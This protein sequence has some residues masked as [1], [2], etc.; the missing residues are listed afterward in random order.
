[1]AKVRSLLEL[2]GYLRKSTPVWV[3]PSWK[4]GGCLEQ[5]AGPSL[6]SG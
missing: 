1:M 3:M 6:R 5:K 2:G 4:V